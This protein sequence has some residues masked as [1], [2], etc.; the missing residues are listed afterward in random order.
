LKISRSDTGASLAKMPVD[1][2]RAYIERAGK[3]VPDSSMIIFVHVISSSGIFV[4]AGNGS[5]GSQSATAV[6]T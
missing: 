1:A 6:R 2:H 5:I 3:G 4:F